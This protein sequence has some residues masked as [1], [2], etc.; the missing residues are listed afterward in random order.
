MQPY[1]DNM[2]SYAP[3]CVTN[4]WKYCNADNNFLFNNFGAVVI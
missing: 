1:L 3:V 2:V 4:E